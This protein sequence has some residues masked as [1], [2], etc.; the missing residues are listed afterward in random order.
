[1]KIDATSR[2]DLEMLA[3]ILMSLPRGAPRG[4]M[5]AFIYGGGKLMVSPWWMR[6]MVWLVQKRTGKN[7]I[8]AW[9][10]ILAS[11]K[12]GALEQAC[13]DGLIEHMLNGRDADPANAGG[14]NQSELDAVKSLCD[15]AVAT[16]ALESAT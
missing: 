11:E 9:G 4:I 12:E 2:S 15:I 6:L 3:A 10:M 1:M 5:L 16:Q 14:F 13:M 7:K 8:Q